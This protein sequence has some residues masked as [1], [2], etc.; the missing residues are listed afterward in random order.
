MVGFRR[1][2]GFDLVSDAYRLLAGRSRKRY[3][4]LIVFRCVIGLVDLL[5]LALIGVIGQLA[6]ANSD[7]AKLAGTAGT[8][9]RFLAFGV[10]DIRKQLVI[11]SIIALLLFSSK[12]ALSIFATKRLFDCLASEE[13]RISSE[14]FGTLLSADLESVHE[15]ATHKISFAIS[16]GAISGISRSLGYYVTV[17]S[18]GFTLLIF[19]T[20]FLV[21]EPKLTLILIVYFSLIGYGLQRFVSGPTKM[22]GETMSRTTIASSQFVQE[23]VRT[24][25][26][27]WVLGVRKFFIYGFAESKK[28]AAFSSARVLTLVQAPRH[29]IDTA[30]IVG[31]AL[32]GAFE[33]SSTDFQEATKSVAFV[34]I[35]GTRVSPS[36]LS[37]QGALAALR[38]A[39]SEG[40]V[41]HEVERRVSHHRSVD[42]VTSSLRMSS[43]TGGLEVDVRNLTF[44]YRDTNVPALREVSFRV[45][46]GSMTAIMGPSGSGKS[47]LAD[48][49]IGVLPSNGCVRIAGHDPSELI[50]ANPGIVGYV[51]QETVLTDASIAENVALGLS[52]DELNRERVA[53]CLELVGLDTFIADLSAGMDTDV[54]EFG[55]R[56]SG[57]QRQRIGIARALYTRPKLLVMDEVTSALDRA[58]EEAI[59]RLIEN[60]RGSLTV[61]AIAH[62][63]LTVSN[64][65]EV[66][67]LREGA[68]ESIVLSERRVRER[69]T[70]EVGEEN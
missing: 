24:F 25:R 36:L 4:L 69:L 52:A 37:F 11:L 14:L 6:I 8:M 57:G 56:L 39:A 13:T 28:E 9:S 41:F 33:F 68:V 60:L 64:A 35:A 55:S 30:L 2:V 5:A 51:P 45:H 67:S 22:L 53:E 27:G 62:R 31:L 47:T 59:V 49:I 7:G 54:G 18:E 12:A 19:G 29:V 66:V 42:S 43:S 48:L 15:V 32:V 46:P 44:A 70:H 10:D 34:L 17:I 1:V 40:E 26:V 20:V 16:Q 21:I 65:D 3:V 23:G 58:S 38:I 61:I 50:R 63:A